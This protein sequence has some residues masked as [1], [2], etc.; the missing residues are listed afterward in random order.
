M[1]FSGLD[2]YG[3]DD[4]LSEEERMVRD[5]VRRF[6]DE[7]IEPII[8]KHFEDGTFPMELV[9]EFAKLGLLGANLEG[10]GCAGMG[11]VAYGLAMQ[12]LER[13]DSGIR[14]FCSVQGSLAM[15]PIHSFGSEEQKQQYL[16]GMAKGELIG[17]F[18][19]TEPDFGSN[20]TGMITKA[21][22]VGGGYRINGVKRWITNGDLCHLAVVWAKLD[23]MVRGFIVPRG[24]K[25]FSTRKIDDKWSLRASVT[26]ELFFEDCVVGEDAILPGVRG[27]RGPLSCLSQARFGIS[28]GAIGA[29]MSCYD[30][31][32][33]YAKDR[34]QFSRPIAGY[35]LVQHKLTEMVSEITKAQCLTLRLGRLKEAKKV[36]PPQ[37]SLAKRNN[38]AMALNIARMARD[39][40]GGNGITYAYSPGRHMMNLETVY[41]YE[42]THDIHTLIVGQDVT[43]LAAFE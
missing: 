15:Y 33:S 16:P 28:W 17:C 35:Q 34:K 6:V 11:D 21:E 4:E 24:T 18:G 25:G 29:A 31:A 40:L 42:G 8:A 22:K 30:T 14:S 26:S 3:I 9:P 43:G 41:T 19:L 1:G 13:G 7:R 32:L 23:G 20:P 2:Y 36:R 27:M 5:N 39:I 10:Y 37:I 38:V 12:E